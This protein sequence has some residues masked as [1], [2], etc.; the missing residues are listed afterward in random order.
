MRTLHMGDY[1]RCSAH[2]SGAQSHDLQV[3]LRTY[4]QSTRSAEVTPQSPDMP[5]GK[6]LAS[7]S[8]DRLE[9]NE[10]RCA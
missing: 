10:R 2:S 9:E 5:S 6:K 7:P 8:G 3:A 4:S 1:L